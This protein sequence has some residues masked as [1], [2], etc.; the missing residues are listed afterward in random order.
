MENASY[1]KQKTKSLYI[2]S[3]TCFAF[4]I[5]RCA[6]PTQGITLDMMLNEKKKKIIECW[7]F[8]HTK[9]RKNKVRIL[10]SLQSIFSLLGQ[11]P[12]E[13]FRNKIKN[14]NYLLK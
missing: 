4:R 2:F 13:K 7:P 5:S 12:K 10:F 11:R 6:S 8:I 14:A 3:K 9:K 1:K